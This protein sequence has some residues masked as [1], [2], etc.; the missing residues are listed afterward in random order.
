MILTLYVAQ[1]HL[2]CRRARSSRSNAPSR[3]EIPARLS[4]PP[5]ANRDSPHSV[6]CDSGV[7]S[8]WQPMA[9]SC[10]LACRHSMRTH[11]QE[12]RNS[13]GADAFTYRDMRGE[14]PNPVR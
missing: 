1:D 8:R 7:F 9:D 14:L 2:F 4:K 3:H 5:H 11:F 13:I 12:D 10:G 6:Q